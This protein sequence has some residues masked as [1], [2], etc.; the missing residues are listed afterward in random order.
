MTARADAA[1]CLVFAQRAVAIGAQ[2]VVL[3]DPNRAGIAEEITLF[4]TRQRCR[5]GAVAQKA[6][7]VPTRCLLRPA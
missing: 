7:L 2:E 3:F 1:S 6:G 4:I 5:N